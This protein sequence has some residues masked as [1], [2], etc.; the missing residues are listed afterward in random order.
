[1]PGSAACWPIN[2]VGSGSGKTYGVLS[3]VVNH[4]TKKERE[5]HVLCAGDGEGAKLFSD[6]SEC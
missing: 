6:Y 4:D 5:N 1:V 2:L 3:R